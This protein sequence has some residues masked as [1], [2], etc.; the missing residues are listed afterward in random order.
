MSTLQDRVIRAFERR[1]KSAEHGERVTRAALARAAGVRQPSVTDWFNGKTLSLKGKTLLGAAAYLKVRPEWL[2][3]DK[4]PMEIETSTRRTARPFAT[5]A[6]DRTPHDGYIRLEV[7]A[8]AA[9]GP[10]RFS[11]QDSEVVRHV[12]VLET[13]VRQTL[14]ASPTQLRVLTA[15]GHSMTGVIEDGDVLFVE[16]CTSFENDGLYVLTVGDLL[17]VKRLRLR[18]TDRQLSIESTDGSTPELVPLSMIDD[19]VRIQGRVIGAWAL[20]R[21]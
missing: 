14:R 16:P 18:V 21:L 2:G 13:W 5:D 12:D 15:R 4:G 10:G 11:P 20:R 8:E 6:A 9:A 1:E 7:M 17:R 3:S 19:S